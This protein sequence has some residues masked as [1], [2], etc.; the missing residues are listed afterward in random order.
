MHR[1]RSRSTSAPFGATSA[2]CARRSGRRALGGRQGR[3]LRARRRGRRR[4]RRWERAQALCVATVAEALPLRREFPGVRIL[5]MGPASDR[6]I[7]QARDADLDL[8]VSDDAI[9]EG[10]ARPSQAR[11][12]HGPVGPVRAAGTSGRG[13][14]R[15]DPPRDGRQRPDFARAQLERFARRPRAVTSLI[16]HAANSAAALRL[17][18]SRLDAARCGIAA[19]RPLTV[20]RAPCRRRAGARAALGQP[21][22][23]VR[24]WPRARARATGGASRPSARPGSASSRRVR[25]RLPA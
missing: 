5:V 4:A 23:Q 22:A 10:R 24:R 16:R 8:A 13:R 12:G 14:R 20:Q 1:R 18:E 7:A 11:H 15:D 25:G 19:L 3:R 2:R 17:P 21:L 6:E 9:P